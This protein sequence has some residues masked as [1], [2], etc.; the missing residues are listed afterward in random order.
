M[1][2]VYTCRVDGCS[3]AIL[4][5]QPQPSWIV[6]V[7]ALADGLYIYLTSTSDR[8][9]ETARYREASRDK[10]MAHSNCLV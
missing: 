1:P 10:N 5:L 7:K 2:W 4:T 9:L 6:F 3:S 8:T